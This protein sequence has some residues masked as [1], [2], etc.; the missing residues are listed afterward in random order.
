MS[1][2]NAKNRKIAVVAVVAGLVLCGGGA[3]FAYWTSTGSGSGQATTGESTDFVV[4]SSA[5]TGGP[6]TP[7]G[8][9]QTV[10]FTVANP[11]TGAQTLED[12]TI[13]VAN[14]NGTEWVL[15]PGCTFADYV[16]GVPT[17]VYGV[18]AGGADVDGTVT[19]TM[20]E[21]GEDQNACQD[22]IVPLY[23]SAS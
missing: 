3:A 9:S 8:P 11:S 21:T 15:V 10:A 12:V 22:A 7:G 4:T 13:T 1:T 5:A 18:I 19:I 17:I 2:H 6:L 14:A 23:I 16:I 20:L